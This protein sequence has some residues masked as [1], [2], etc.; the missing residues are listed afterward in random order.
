MSRLCDAGTFV[1]IGKLRAANAY[2]SNENNNSKTYLPT[3]RK[4]KKGN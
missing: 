1:V 3:L 4:W 2:I